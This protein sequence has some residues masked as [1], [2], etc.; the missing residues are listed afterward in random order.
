MICRYIYI[1]HLKKLK[2]VVGSLTSE[3]FKH[4]DK[5]EMAKIED[6]ELFYYYIC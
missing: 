3:N 4:Y 6:D 5:V 1:Y 2:N